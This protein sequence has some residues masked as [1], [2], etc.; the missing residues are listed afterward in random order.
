[1]NQ[2]LIEIKSCGEPG[3]HPLVY[4]GGWR[5][6]FLNDTA[7]FHLEQIREMQRH[8]TSDEVFLLLQGSC[9]LYVAAALESGIG[10]ISAAEL[11]PGRM[12]NV[13]KGVWHTHVTGPGAKI[14]IIEDADVSP[15]NSELI[16]VD[17]RALYEA[18]NRKNGGGSG[19]A[20]NVFPAGNGK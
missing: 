11:E 2:E 3:Y 4:F 18:Q 9:T 20:G 14:A 6:A 12:Y 7:R 17:P 15:D 19:G 13:R 16:P 1:M 8:N 10:E 5:V